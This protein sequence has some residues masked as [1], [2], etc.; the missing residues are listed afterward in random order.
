MEKF[1]EILC[2][3]LCIKFFQIFNF[4]PGSGDNVIMRSFITLFFSSNVTVMT[5]LKGPDLGG[6]YVEHTEEYRSAYKI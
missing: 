2:V 3:C 6:A 1:T 4:P 5:K